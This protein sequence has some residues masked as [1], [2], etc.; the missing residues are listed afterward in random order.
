M[1]SLVIALVV[2]IL[3]V[4]VASVTLGGDDDAERGEAV[5]EAFGRLDDSLDYGD[6]GY[7]ELKSC[8]VGDARELARDVSG[9][10][11]VSMSVLDGAVYTD[12][13]E[14]FDGYP[15][16]IQ[17]FVTSDP[18]DGFGP[19]AVGFSVSGV[20]SSSY[21]DFLLDDAYESGI[22]VTIDV[23]RRH[24]GQVF[25][26]DLFGYCYRAADLSG[27]GADLVDRVNGVVLSVYL[28][29]SERTA[30]EVVEA[31][32]RIVGDMVRSLVDFVDRNP[33]PDTY[34][35]TGEITGV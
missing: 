14:R 16:I 12:A 30:N 7:V 35:D 31:L 9:V 33:V 22:E 10:V 26:G 17:C 11:D 5:A 20:P 15:A 1:T 19:T 24:D 3:V 27:C 25:D 13:Y 23:Q 4:V 34:S 18:D 29:G 32:D 8:P 6:D 21:R 28:Q 2:A